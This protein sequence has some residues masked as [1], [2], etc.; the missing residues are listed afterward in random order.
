MYIYTYLYIY[1][2]IYVYVYLY[3]GT[4]TW[5]CP[6]REEFPYIGMPLYKDTPM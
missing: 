1:V 3:E 2:Y 5:G 4:I 6:Y